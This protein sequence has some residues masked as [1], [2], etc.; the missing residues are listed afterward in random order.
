MSC[1][2]PHWGLQLILAYSWARPAIHAA[3]EGRGGRFLFLLFLNFIHF[4]ISS[5]SLS[6]ISST[7]SSIFCLPF[8]GRRHKMTHRVDMLLKPNTNNQ[9]KIQITVI[10]SCTILVYTIVAPL[11]LFPKCLACWVKILKYLSYVFTLTFHA[12]C[13]LRRQFA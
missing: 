9:N 5:L 13:L 2:L 7:D 10:C 1:I 6:F 3:G 8:S 4:P 12:N 11:L